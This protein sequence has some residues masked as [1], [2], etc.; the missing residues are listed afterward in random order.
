V[1]A[2]VCLDFEVVWSLRNCSFL[3][4]AEARFSLSLRLNNP[5]L[6]LM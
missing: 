2:F 1:R 5:S 3:F 6:K 4:R